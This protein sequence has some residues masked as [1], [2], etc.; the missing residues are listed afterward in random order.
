[1]CQGLRTDSQ[2]GS[3][4]FWVT[5]ANKEARRPTQRRGANTSPR[6]RPTNAPVP[7]VAAGAKLSGQAKEANGAARVTRGGRLQV[8]HYPGRKRWTAAPENDRVSAARKRA[9][10]TRRGSSP[11]ESRSRASCPRAAPSEPAARR[12]SVLRVI[13]K[14]PRRGER[15]LLHRMTHLPPFRPCSMIE[16]RR[17]SSRRGSKMTHRQTS[18]YPLFRWQ[19]RAG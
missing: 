14:M 1:M 7:I 2:E 8:S 12:P 16:A 4:S 5:R 6:M 3:D 10:R 9:K 13:L 11:T 15:R 17:R 19:G 18:H